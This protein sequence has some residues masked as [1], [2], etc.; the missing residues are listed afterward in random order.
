MART[1]GKR[2]KRR[3]QETLEEE[4]QERLTERG[5]EWK[6]VRAIT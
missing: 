3:C 1:K 6:G 2:P 5:T 4:T